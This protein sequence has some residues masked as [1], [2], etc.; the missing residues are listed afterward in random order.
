MILSM[1]PR[2][3]IELSAW[4]PV[5]ASLTMSLAAS[6]GAAADIASVAPV[7][8]ASRS[9]ERSRE[10]FGASGALSPSNFLPACRLREPLPALRRSVRRGEGSDA[11][12][13][14]KR[15]GRG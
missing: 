9:G 3:V 13:G 6:K 4:A 10:G 7:E 5:T 1:L 8:E 12:G 11:V 15:V 2:S 14:R